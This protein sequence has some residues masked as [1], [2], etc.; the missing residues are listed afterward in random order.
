M[1]LKKCGNMVRMTV[2]PFF[3]PEN[4]DFFGGKCIFELEFNL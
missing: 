2:L 1:V 4:L 3:C